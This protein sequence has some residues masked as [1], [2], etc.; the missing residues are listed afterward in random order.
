[1]LGGYAI[2][3]STR[4]ASRLPPKLLTTTNRRRAA[5]S[6]K[7][8]NLDRK[9]HTAR[10]KMRARD[11]PPEA[12][13]K[14]AARR[15]RSCQ[16]SSFSVAWRLAHMNAVRIRLGPH[17]ERKEYPQL[18]PQPWGGPTRV[19]L[20]LLACC[21]ACPCLACNAPRRLYLQTR[22]RCDDTRMQSIAH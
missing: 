4:L 16:P 18:I 15:G 21:L 2:I 17:G 7:N 8:P 9:S 10:A 14:H 20:S 1:M 6:V 11:L 3:P 22:W 19:R 13:H 12:R 5:N